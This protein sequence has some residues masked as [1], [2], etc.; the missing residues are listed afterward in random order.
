MMTVSVYLS[1]REISLEP[2][3]R[4]LPIFVRIAYVRGSVILLYVD[5]RPH[6]LLP[7]RG[8]GSAKHGRSVIYDCLV[9]TVLLLQ[10]LLHLKEYYAYIS[11]SVTYRSY[12]VLLLLGQLPNYF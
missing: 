4:S 3:A 7:R 10:Y 12:A 1:A 11:S 6:R 9:T 2:H 8:D 5:D